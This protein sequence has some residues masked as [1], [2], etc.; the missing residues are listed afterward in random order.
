MTISFSRCTQISPVFS[1]AVN[2]YCTLLVSCCI[3]ALFSDIQKN[4]KE[5]ENNLS[6]HDIWFVKGI[7]SKH[8]LI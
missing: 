8:A 7:Q 1:S 3:L 6:K 4:E 5:K 2:K